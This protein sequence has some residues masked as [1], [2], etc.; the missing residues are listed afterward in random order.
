MER[1]I[2]GM[3]GVAECNITY[4]MYFDS[5]ATKASSNTLATG[6]K[7]LQPTV[8]CVKSPSVPLLLHIAAHG[9]T[10]ASPL[11]SL[12][13]LLQDARTKEVCI[14]ASALV[15][16]MVTPPAWAN[17]ERANGCLAV[18]TELHP[19]QGRVDAVQK[20]MLRPVL[21]RL[22]QHYKAADA[23]A[24]AE[25]SAGPPGDHARCGVSALCGPQL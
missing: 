13:V 5:K 10:A 20:Q 3:P 25:R 11:A 8:L 9:A 16:R 22:E 2:R 18:A 17:E 4:E 6:N 7:N 19:A 24:G 1:I 14:G 21:A 15:F 23:K 12:P